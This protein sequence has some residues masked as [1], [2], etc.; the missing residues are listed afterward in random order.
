MAHSLELKDI[1]V[2]PEDFNGV[3]LVTK[4]KQHLVELYQS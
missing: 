4:F 3:R 2:K 1:D